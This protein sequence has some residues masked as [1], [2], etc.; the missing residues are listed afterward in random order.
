[1]GAGEGLP[2][3]K[4]CGAIVGDMLVA[5]GR[6]GASAKLWAGVDPGLAAGD[7]SLWPQAMAVAKSNSEMTAEID[8]RIVDVL[9]RRGGGR[10]RDTQLLLLPGLHFG[11]FVGAAA[12]RKRRLLR[13]EGGV[14][15]MISTKAN[16]ATARSSRGMPGSRSMGHTI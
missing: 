10:Q 11:R 12:A 13:A 14:N 2:V 1:M 7:G 15:L 6:I 5:E 8:S 16:K 4:G 3:A 9:W